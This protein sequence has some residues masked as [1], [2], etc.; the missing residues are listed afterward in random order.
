MKR[1]YLAIAVFALFFDHVA[2]SQRLLKGIDIGGQPGIP[3]ANTA[4]NMIYVPNMGL[5]TL[6]V[7]SGSSGAIVANVPLGQQPIAAAFNP[8]TNVVYVS[9]TGTGT[10]SGAIAE[11][12]ASSN[13]LI[14]TV[15]VG[16]AV[17]IAVNPVTNLVYFSNSQW[18]VSVL[19]ATANT[20]I[21]TITTGSQCCMEGIAVDATTNRIYVTQEVLGHGNVNQLVVING[22]TNKPTSF[23][24]TGSFAVGAPVVDSTLNRV[25]VPDSAGGGLY[26]LNAGTGKVI[27]TVLPTYYGPVAINSSTHRIAAIGVPGA[28]YEVGF[29]S[30][31][32][33]A[34]VGGVVSFPPSASAIYLVSGSG[35]RYYVGFYNNTSIAVI[36]GPQT[37]AR[38]A[39]R[40]R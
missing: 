11:V 40:R 15:P 20:V 13:T 19:D 35:N 37:G 24:V 2:F 39:T 3:A 30:P 25:Y 7:I 5:N 22:S 10:G 16:L 38:T 34:Q 31:G 17:F 28:V 36:S 21:G 9:T 8:V 1:I 27:D 6:T 14:T 4:A 33:F 18:T 23:P 26:V 12:D 32:T 29:F